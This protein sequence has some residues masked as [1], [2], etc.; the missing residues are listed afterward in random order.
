MR[1]G[2]LE[3]AQRH[4]LRSLELDPNRGDTYGIIVQLAHRLRQPGAVALF[5]PLVRIVESRLREEMTLW[6]RTWDQP[7]DPGGYLALARFLIRT[8]DLRKAESQLEQAL[9]LRPGWQEAEQEL[10]RVRR[11]LA[12]VEER[13]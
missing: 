9:E 2:R 5:S 12:V 8:A 6:R 3:A 1:A 4:L 11:L 10:A 7:E 13:I